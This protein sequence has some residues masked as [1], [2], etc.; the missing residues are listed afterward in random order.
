MMQIKRQMSRQISE[1]QEETRRHIDSSF[2]NVASEIALLRGE[3]LGFS[4]SPLRPRS[5][6]CFGRQ[7]EAESNCGQTL[8]AASSGSP[9]TGLQNI[10]TPSRQLQQGTGSRVPSRVPSQERLPRIPS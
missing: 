2:S 5:Q 3:V 8:Q 6:V 10:P 9:T 4:D 1:L 7:A